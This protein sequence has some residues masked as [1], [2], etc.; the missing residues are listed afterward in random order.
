VRQQFGSLERT[1]GQGKHDK[2]QVE[3]AVFEVTQKLAVVLGLG[4]PHLDVRP[5]RGEFGQDAG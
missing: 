1:S 2:C 4:Q 3:P 5:R